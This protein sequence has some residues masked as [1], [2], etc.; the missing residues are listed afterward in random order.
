MKERRLP[1]TSSPLEFFARHPVFSL[2]EFEAAYEKMGRASKSASRILAW[3]VKEG[4]LFNVRRGLFVCADAFDPWVLASRL[5]DDVVISHDGALSF[6]R[7][8]GLGNR[9]SFTTHSRTSRVV[10][11][12]DL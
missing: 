8:T 9:I 5:A 11:D 6:H 7:V 12:E 2:D 10:F 3:H 1:W 4:R